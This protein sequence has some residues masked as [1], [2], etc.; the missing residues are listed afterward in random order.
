[1][2]SHLLTHISMVCIAALSATSAAAQGVPEPG[3]P[4][5]Q[6]AAGQAVQQAPYPFAAPGS[7]RENLDTKALRDEL[8]DD[9]AATMLDPAGI[10]EI[11]RRKLD[12]QA[13]ATYPGYAGKALPIAVHKEIR[14]S[15]E[16]G[17]A[18][19][20]VRF[21]A[22]VATPISFIDKHGQP[23]PIRDVV[24]S[25]KRF[26]L[27]G[28]GCGE[29]NPVDTTTRPSTIYIT[30]CDFWTWSSFA[31][32][33][34]GVNVPI[35][36]MAASGATGDD[37]RNNYI[38]VPVI[39]RV[40]GVSPGD[41]V[42]VAGEYKPEDPKPA[43]RVA[44]PDPDPQADPILLAFASG[45]PP[46]GAYRLPA[47]GP[48]QAWAYAGQ[49]YLVTSLKDVRTVSPRYSATGTGSAGTVWRY[50]TPVFRVIADTAGGSYVIAVE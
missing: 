43:P 47:A 19:E 1:M 20:S 4:R 2:R 46:T 23:W 14:F 37:P 28:N 16:I 21:A 9:A 27:N 11:K 15:P 38:D 7:E 10:A 13:A 8:I 30:A 17:R 31:V 25:A 42:K 49:T 50:D 36:F 34:E 40:D 44:R 18:P 6:A 48:A 5:P 26:S 22:H 33:L 41:K 12:G 29:T 35:T 24:Y 39:V 3:E 32:Q 45:T